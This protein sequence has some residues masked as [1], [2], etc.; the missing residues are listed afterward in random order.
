M[1]A[2]DQFRL[3]IAGAGQITEV[4]TGLD[5]KHRECSKRIMFDLFQ[6]MPVHDQIKN[7]YKK[8]K[9]VFADMD[10]S[11]IGLDIPG[12]CRIWRQAEAF[13]QIL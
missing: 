13:V 9:L 2:G 3:L 10:A 7:S 11:Y 8:K 12:D 5:P 1:K 4:T 6:T